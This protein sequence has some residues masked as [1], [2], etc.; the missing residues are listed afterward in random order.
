MMG[1]VK[2]KK[3]RERNNVNN[4]KA[5]ATHSPLV[6]INMDSLPFMYYL[7][8]VSPPAVLVANANAILIIF[9]MLPH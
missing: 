5:L 4:S 3:V 7:I 9:N 8:C 1:E 6:S 2:R